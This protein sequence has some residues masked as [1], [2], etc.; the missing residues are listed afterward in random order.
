M[1]SSE[2]KIDVDRLI[3]TLGDLPS[4]PAIVSAVIG[5][6]TDLNTD[7]SELAKV[8]SAD[9]ALTAK[10]LRLSNSSFYGRLKQVATVNEA[11]MILG[12][13]TLRSLVIASSTHRLYQQRDP[14]HFLP[15]LWEHSLAT[16]VAARLLGRRLR[17]PQ[18]EEAFICGLLH[19][20]GKLVM[21]QKL[22]VEYALIRKAACKEHDWCS[23]EK[24][25]L[26]FTHV[27]IGVALLEKWNFP[28]SLVEAVAL[29]HTEPEPAP[30]RLPT[31]HQLLWLADPIADSIL[32]GSVAGEPV[33]WETKFRL[34][35]I[36]WDAARIAECLVEFEE[37]Y[38]Q[39]RKLFQFGT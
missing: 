10:V 15:V 7:L 35:N 31:L 19:D 17:H 4:S 21:T 6:T 14:T 12:F 23:L 33:D 11:I 5:L 18:M 24:D 30:D 27:D 13:Y 9:Q 29:H 1:L 36:P 38:E 39:E 32:D 20:I 2:P 26:G 3:T 25:R 16:A 28:R 37:N 8:L 34:A 22:T